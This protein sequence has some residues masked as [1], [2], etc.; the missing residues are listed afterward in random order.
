MENIATK[1]GGNF[2]Y[3]HG[4]QPKLDPAVSEVLKWLPPNASLPVGPLKWIDQGKRERV[5]VAVGSNE[6]R[7]RREKVASLGRRR[8]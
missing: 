7:E 6:G 3:E 5:V 8:E 4:M 2:D 1:F